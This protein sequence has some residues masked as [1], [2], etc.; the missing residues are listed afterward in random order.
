MLCYAREY[1]AC[2]SAVC[3][4]AGARL[5]ATTGRSVVEGWP[6][7]CASVCVC[8]CV[9]VRV[10]A[11]VCV[12]VCACLCV[13]V[14]TRALCGCACFNASLHALACVS[15]RAS[16][17]VCGVRV[18]ACVAV[19]TSGA[20]GTSVKTGGMGHGGPSRR[21]ARTHALHAMPTLTSKHARTQGKQ[22]TRASTRIACPRGRA[23]ESQPRTHI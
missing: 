15:S 1:H 23:E 16:G 11:C 17:C 19:Q 10:C 12:C 21:T 14:C 22:Q 4:S 3:V 8:V 20:D 18:R 7:P 2:A 13:C 6:H 5:R 9:C